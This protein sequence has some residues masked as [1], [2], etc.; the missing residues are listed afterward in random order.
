MVKKKALVFRHWHRWDGC[1]IV[2]RSLDRPYITE[3]PLHWPGVV[4]SGRVEDFVCEPLVSGGVLQN[5][6]TGEDIVD[7]EVTVRLHEVA[8]WPVAV[9][10]K[11]LEGIGQ[12]RKQRT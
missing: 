4:L 2:Y 7:S 1:N 8:L 5:Q 9:A 12:S 10:Q 6:G 3:Y 11:P